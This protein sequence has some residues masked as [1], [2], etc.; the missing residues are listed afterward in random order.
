MSKNR[1]LKID[2]K[3]FRNI[4]P[5]SNHFLNLAWNNNHGWFGMKIPIPWKYMPIVFSGAVHVMVLGGGIW[6]GQVTESSLIV[7]GSEHVEWIDG[8]WR[9]R[10]RFWRHGWKG[11][12]SECAR[13]REAIQQFRSSS[14]DLFSADGV[15][16][17]RLTLPHLAKP[18]YECYIFLNLGNTTPFDRN[19]AWRVVDQFRPIPKYYQIWKLKEVV[20]KFKTYS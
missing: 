7:K 13:T 16:S 14:K 18:T 9:S 8:D 17:N 20:C 15:A 1:C 6:K 4:I 5:S 12:P 3:G 19:Y 10:N 11:G 2:F